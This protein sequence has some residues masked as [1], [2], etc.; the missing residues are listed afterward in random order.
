MLSML[1]DGKLVW[2]ACSLLRLYRTVDFIASGRA[3]T[4]QRYFSAFLP[5]VSHLATVGGEMSHRDAILYEEQDIHM[6]FLHP[7]RYLRRWRNIELPLI[8]Q[9][10]LCRA[11]LP[12]TKISHAVAPCMSL[13]R[14]AG[15]ICNI[16]AGGCRSSPNLC[17]IFRVARMRS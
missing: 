14:T 5:A 6:H 8:S 1:L 13:Q 16:T 7:R 12:C 15:E 2:R 3:A 10:L 4:I 9:P 17:T 11:V